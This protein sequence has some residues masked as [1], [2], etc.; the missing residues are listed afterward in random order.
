[1]TAYNVGS[2]DNA[3]ITIHGNEL[4][5]HTCTEPDSDGDGMCDADEIAAGTDP[6]DP[7]SVLKI[8]SLTGGST[9]SVTLTW[10]S[11]P[12][13]TYR[14]ACKDNP[15]DPYWSDLSGPIAAVGAATSWEDA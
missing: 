11:V 13:K 9:G 12:G 2:P 5:P 1:N 7:Q 14:V 4:P 3:T 10:S 15:A 8:I 6:T